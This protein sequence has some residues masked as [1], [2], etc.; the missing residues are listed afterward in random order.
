MVDKDTWRTLVY[1]LNSLLRAMEQEKM[2]DLNDH[3][4]STIPGI[5]IVRYPY[6]KEHLESERQSWS[7]MTTIHGTP[8][9]RVTQAEQRII[10]LLEECDLRNLEREP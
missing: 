8:I 10:R 4:G 1:G 2:D 7:E 5:Q 9:N 6:S 3:Y